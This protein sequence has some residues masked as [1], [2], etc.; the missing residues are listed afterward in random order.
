MAMNSLVYNDREINQR[1][2]MLSLTDM[3]RAVSG[4]DARRPSDWLASKDGKRFVGYVETSA[5]NSGTQLIQTLNEGGTWNTWA[6]WQIALAYAKYLAPEFHVWCNEVVKAHM[7][8]RGVPVQSTSVVISVREEEFLRT[9]RDMTS[10]INAI[11]ENQNKTDHRVSHVET[12]VSGIKRDIIEMRAEIHGIA[13]KGRKRIKDSV[14]QEI[15][16]HTQAL[17]GKCP[18]CGTADVIVRES[19]SCFAEFDH[20]YQNS[21]ADSDHVWLICKPCH[22]ELTNGRVARGDRQDEFNA[23]QKKR[24]RLPGVQ[25]L[26]EWGGVA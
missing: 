2:E 15:T 8:G 5:G 3:W 13:T 1:G 9:L 16:K 24:R 19:P 23:F 17:G 11:L 7:E 12:D 14:K 18:C 4:E 21:Q 20:F 10:G 26:L 22:A 25:P 6:H